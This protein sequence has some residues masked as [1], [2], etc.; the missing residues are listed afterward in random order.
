DL[1]R[2]GA[3]VRV[4]TDAG[5][6]HARHA[7]LATN[8]FPS[9]LRRLRLMTVPVYDYVLMTESLDE[10]QLGSVG[11]AHRQG[12]GD[13]A[14]QFHYYRLTRDNRIL[15]GGYDAV[16]Y[17]GGRI[18]PERDQRDATFEVLAAHFAAT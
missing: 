2:D 8:A 16:Y 11:W 1:A 12:V 17:Y 4:R 7:V 6:V 5:A 15:W 10:R 9:L 18:S 14:N 13:A 3:G